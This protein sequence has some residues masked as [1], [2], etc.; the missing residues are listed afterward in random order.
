MKTSLW[1]LPWDSLQQL[2]AKITPRS[3]KGKGRTR[4]RPVKANGGN[5]TDER[6]S[7]ED[8]KSKKGL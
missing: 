8:A 6:K 5:V 7:A 2:H 3:A 4:L 1:K